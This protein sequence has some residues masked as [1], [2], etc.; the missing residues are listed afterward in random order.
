MTAI[1]LFTFIN[2]FDRQVGTLDH[3]LTKGAEFCQAQGASGVNCW[4]DLRSCRKAQIAK[5]F[6]ALTIG[7]PYA[8][9]VPRAALVDRGAPTLASAGTGGGE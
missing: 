9:R 4:L 6:Y 8:A 1:S 3:L 2:L 7:D 5:R